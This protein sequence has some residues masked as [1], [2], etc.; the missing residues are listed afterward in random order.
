MTINQFVDK[1]SEETKV[2]QP[3]IGTFIPGATYNILAEEI[4]SSQHFHSC[5]QNL[6]SDHREVNV[7]LMNCLYVR[8]EEILDTN[9]GRGNEFKSRGNPFR[10]FAFVHR[11]DLY[12]VK[13]SSQFDGNFRVNL[14]PSH[15]NVV[16]EVTITYVEP[17]NG[18]NQK[19]TSFL[20]L[21][22]YL[23]SDEHKEERDSLPKDKI[24][25]PC[26]TLMGYYLP[27]EYKKVIRGHLTK[28]A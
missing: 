15:L 28:D 16:P 25:L 17:N 7:P 2:K 20:E 12:R 27:E 19:V 26:S 5:A 6:L 14:H 10:V 4:N 23:V 13:Y 9:F 22:D 11:G 1:S 24:M 8:D 3:Y 21:A 18:H